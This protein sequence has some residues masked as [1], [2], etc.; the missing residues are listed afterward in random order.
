SAPRENA[1]AEQGVLPS[2]VRVEDVRGDLHVH[3]TLS[4]DGRSTLEEIVASAAERGYEYLA[5]TDHA[6]NLA[7]SGV[8]RE[9]LARQRKEIDALRGRFPGMLLLHGSG[10]NIG[11]DGSVDYDPEFRRT[12]EWRAARGASDP[13][14]CPRAP[15]AAHT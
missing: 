8:S 5:L 9:A 3:T 11:R 6:E 15:N 13:P 4:G 7:M 10:L 2:A 1:A 12:L 14:P